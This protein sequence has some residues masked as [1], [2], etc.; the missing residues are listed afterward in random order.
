[1]TSSISFNLPTRKIRV[2]LHLW[3]PA[4]KS[5]L[6]L[7]LVGFCID[8]RGRETERI[9][10]EQETTKKLLQRLKLVSYAE[11]DLDNSSCRRMQIIGRGKILDI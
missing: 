3:A 1:M 8:W 6:I 10:D 5:S 9:I 11:Q 2:K 4:V 7:L